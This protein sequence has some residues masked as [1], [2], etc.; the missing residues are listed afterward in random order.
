MLPDEHA[1]NNFMCKP[2][3]SVDK[4]SDDPILFFRKEV[5]HG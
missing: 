3:F 2:N 4:D 5:T 1:E